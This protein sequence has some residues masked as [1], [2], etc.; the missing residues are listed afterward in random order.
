MNLPRIPQ[1]TTP[2]FAFSMVE[3]SIQD[4]LAKRDF[5]KAEI[6]KVLYFFNTD[7]PECVFCGSREVARWDHLIP[8]TKGGETVLGNMVLACSSCDDSKQALPFDEWL[9]S[10]AKCSPASRRVKNIDQRLER[11]KAYQQHFGYTPRSLEKR[12][13]KGELRRLKMIRFRLQNIR[14]DIESLID[15]YRAR[16]NNL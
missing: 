5:G 4:C 1:R 8:F 16:T 10:D 14:K 13:T 7:P 6:D 15:D 11:I 9:L 12:L 2:G 3:R